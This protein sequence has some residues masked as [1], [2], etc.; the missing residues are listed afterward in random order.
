MTWG[1]K[2]GEGNILDGDPA[3]EGMLTNIGGSIRLPAHFCGVWGHKP[4][5]GLLP[6]IGP[7]LP[8]FEKDG[9]VRSGRG[10]KAVANQPCAKSQLINPGESALFVD[11]SMLISTHNAHLIF[12]TSSHSPGILV[13]VG[14]YQPVGIEMAMDTNVRV[15]FDKGGHY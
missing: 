5:Y 12:T 13:L 9:A 6:L 3:S 7:V 8:P 2:A 11:L 1:R 15:L 14:A 10:G 4:T